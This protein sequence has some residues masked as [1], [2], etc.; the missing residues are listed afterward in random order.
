MC[1]LVFYFSH[2][3]GIL[4][5]WSYSSFLVGEVPDTPIRRQNKNW[6]FEIHA[7]KQSKWRAIVG[8]TIN[9]KTSVKRWHRY[10]FCSSKKILDVFNYLLQI[11]INNGWNLN[12]LPS[13]QPC[14]CLIMFSFRIMKQSQMTKTCRL[15]VNLLS[16]MS[17]RMIR[18]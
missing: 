4:N 6:K 10:E 9:P 15:L 7:R 18:L 14:R 3:F 1:I 2:E 16:C 5:F 17:T 12:G 13:T 11:S 8:G